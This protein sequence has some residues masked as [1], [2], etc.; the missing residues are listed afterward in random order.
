MLVPPSPDVSTTNHSSHKV[1]R[2][3]VRNDAI[4]GKVKTLILLND[5]EEPN[6]L[7]QSDTGLNQA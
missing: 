6:E 1:M 3:S 7:I 5:K 4:N 2:L